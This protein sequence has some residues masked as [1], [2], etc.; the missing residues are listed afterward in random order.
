MEQ[1]ARGGTDLSFEQL[2]TLRLLRPQAPRL[3]LGRGEGIPRGL[4]LPLQALDV[5]PGA[6]ELLGGAGELGLDLGQPGGQLAAG[7]GVLLLLGGELRLEPVRVALGEVP[8]LLGAGRDGAGLRGLRARASGV[9][10]GLRALLD[11]LDDAID[12]LLEVR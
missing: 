1:E 4:G 12:L 11:E 9:L 2:F 5:A 10:V 7:R 6:L 8:L 3:E